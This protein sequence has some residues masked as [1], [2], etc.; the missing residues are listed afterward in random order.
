[1]QIIGTCTPA[2]LSQVMCLTPASCPCSGLGGREEQ[3]GSLGSS[4]VI[5]K[6]VSIEKC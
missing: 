2:A 5:S 1:M 3:A 4:A 6:L